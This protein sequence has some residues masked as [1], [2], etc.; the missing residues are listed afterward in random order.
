MIPT[1]DALEK[2][3]I[4]K[5]TWRLIPFLLLLYIVAWLDRVNVGFAAL[6]MN[7]DLGFSASV[8]GFGAGVFFIGYALCEVPSNLIL[9]RVGARRW[10]ARIMVTWGVLAVAMMFVRSATSFYVLRFL[11]GVAE[12]GF[13]PGIIYYLSNWYPAE[14]RARAVSMFMIGIPLAIVVGGPVAGLLL[15]MNGLLGLT[16]WQWLFL[17]EGA[18]AIVLGVVVWAYLPDGPAQAHWLAPDQR[19]WLSGRIEAEQKAALARHGVGLRQALLHPTVWLLAMIMFAC[20]CGSY[21]LT[22]WVPQII[23]GLSG[24]SDLEVGVISAI[25]YIGAAIGMVVIGINS[26]RTGERILHIAVP[27]F[28]A[29]VG[30]TLSAFMVSPVPGMIALT[31]AAIG[32]LGSRG[33]FWSL[34]GRFLTSSASAGGIALINTIG[35]LGGFVGPYAVGVVKDATGSFTGGLLLLAALLFVSAIATLRM[36]TAP[37]LA[38]LPVR[39]EPAVS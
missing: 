20:Q 6:Q 38:E 18:P 37:A 32:D 33:P 24:F 29:A 3:T 35:A 31:I 36:R 7:Q 27:A 11:L 34:P 16:G 14:Q 25:P 15:G 30:F 26:D 22:L 13:L 2:A 17:L 1:E 23:K 10:I 39:A 5:V 19:A 21:G 12:A 9:A 4:A 8:Y 28:V